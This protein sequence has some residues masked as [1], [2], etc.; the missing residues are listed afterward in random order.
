MLPL[1]FRQEGF[2][3]RQAGYL[4][5]PVPYEV[6]STQFPRAVQHKVSSASQLDSKVCQTIQDLLHCCCDLSFFKSLFM[7]TEYH[8]I[9][10]GLVSRF[11]LCTLVD[12]E[13]LLGFKDLAASLLKDILDLSCKDMFRNNHT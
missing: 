5:L 7:I 12:I 8:G 13:E 2:H 1:S 11:D 6:C 10:H 9:S 4:L 3:F